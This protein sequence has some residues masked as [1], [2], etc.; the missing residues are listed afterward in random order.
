MQI[1][2]KRLNKEAIIP[3]Y[4]LDGDAAL[5]LTAINRT[6]DN[7]TKSF[8]FHTGLAVEIPQGHVG[9][10]FP[11]SSV[12][13]TPLTLANSVGVID[14]NYRGEIK[15]VFKCQ[16]IYT[17]SYGI[18]NVGDRVAQLMIVPIPAVELIETEELSDSNRGVDGF[19]SS[20]R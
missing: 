3:K 2:V 4:S 9:L 5:D 10:L 11:R 19:G 8:V 14:S 13:K 18:Y 16:N 1:R 20:G 6:Y 17:D 15:V 12:S 7:S